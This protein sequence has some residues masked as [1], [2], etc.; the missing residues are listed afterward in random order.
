MKRKIYAE[1]LD[2]KNNT[3]NK[4]PLMV[5]GVRQAGKTYIIE[6]FAR[7]NYEETVE[8]N[9]KETPSAAEVFSGDLTVDNMVM[10]LR[11][12]FPEKKIVPDKTLIFLDEIQECPEAVTFMKFLVQEGT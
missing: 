3:R 11:F 12:R 1:L 7:D 10:A 8:I 2:W 9:F 4:K 6:Q 5:L